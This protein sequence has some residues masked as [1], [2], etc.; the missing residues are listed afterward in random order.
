M[1]DT[2]SYKPE[3][4]DNSKPSL[5]R[6]GDFSGIKK[7]EFYAGVRASGDVTFRLSAAAEFGIRFVDRWDIDPAAAAVVG[8]VSLT[9]KF[10]AGIST[11]GT[12]PFTYGLEVGAR[13]FARATAPRQFGWAGG[14]VDLTDKWKKTIIEG[15][16]CPDLGPIPSRRSLQGRDLLTIEGRAEDEDRT[17]NV[18]KLE[19]AEPGAYET[20]DG[21]SMHSHS[22]GL[23]TRLISGGHISSLSKRGGVYGPAF[24][25]PVGEFFCPSQDG[26]EG[27]TCEQ[28]YAALKASDEGGVWQDSNRRKREVLTPTST[29][30]ENAIAAYLQVHAHQQ[31]SDG[32][33]HHA[34]D[35]FLQIFEKRADGKPVKACN[36]ECDIE[37]DFPSGGQLGGPNWGWVDPDDCGNFNFGTPLTQRAPN[38]EYHTEHILEAQMIDLFFKHL[39]KRKSKLPDP[40]LN[41]AQGATVS[42]CE[43][44]D[45]LWDVDPFEW[46]GQDTTGGIGTKWNPIMHIAAQLPTRTYETKDFVALESPINTPSKT[47]AW[48]SGSPWATNSWTKDIANY[49]KARTIFFRMRSTMGSRIYQSHS[50]I[51]GTMKRQTDRIGKVLDALDTTLLPDHPRNGFKK[52]SK[53][54]LKSEWLSYMRGQYTT[55]QSKTNGLVNDFLPMMKAAWVTQAEED[56]WEDA[57]GDS[58]TVAAEKKEHRNFIKAIKDF[59]THWNGLPAWTNPL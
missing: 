17:R 1:P 9:T 36:R 14:E 18:S 44:V 12:C 15:G 3:L 22:A 53:Q 13:L 10:E 42:F 16:T 33:G 4:I 48:R 45:A 58:P 5:D 24:S 43:Y 19:A 8:E 28:A 25:L 47:S 56:K 30:N 23:R 29:I 7:P 46:P 54:N 38:T 11:T 49:A 55:M 20:I 27:I 34:A 6:T 26:E 35:D 2:N 50:T 21:M 39:D 57:A 52:W 51:S 32:L 41:A 59:E 31:Q 40:D 37:D